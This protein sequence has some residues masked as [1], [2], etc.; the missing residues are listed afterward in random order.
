MAN[1]HQYV[2]ED[3]QYPES[4][5][6]LVPHTILPQSRKRKAGEIRDSED[7]DD[8]EGSDQEYGWSDGDADELPPPPPQTQGSE[9]ILL[10]PELRDRSEDE[11]EDE[12]E[13][14]EDLESDLESELDQGSHVDGSKTIVSI[15]SVDAEAIVGEPDQETS[16][17]DG[18]EHHDRAER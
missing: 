5:L 9:D 18:F 17:V 6:P 1:E 13:T 3:V 8:L 16:N 11:Y 10:A 4:E 14:V 7:D 15:R 12:D 2:L